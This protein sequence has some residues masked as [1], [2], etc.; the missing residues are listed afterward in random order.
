MKNYATDTR[1]GR[2]IVM[3]PNEVWVCMVL[4]ELYVANPGGFTNLFDMIGVPPEWYPDPVEA[5]NFWH[6]LD[7]LVGV[8][9]EEG[10]VN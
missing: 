7:N 2:S 3:N 9:L 10:P 6:R 5:Q 4:I 8:G 1:E